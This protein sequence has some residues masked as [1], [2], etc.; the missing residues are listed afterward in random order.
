MY[1]DILWPTNIAPYLVYDVNAPSNFVNDP[2]G[3]G[4]LGLTIFFEVRPYGY[5]PVYDNSNVGTSGSDAMRGVAAT[6]INRSRSNN[7]DVSNSPGDPWLTLATKDMSPSIW[8]V[9]KAG[10]GGLQSSFYSKLIAILN[11][12][13]HTQDCDGLMHSWQ[14]AIAMGNEY[15]NFGMRAPVSLDTT[16]PFPGTLFFNTDDSVPSVSKAQVAFLRKLGFSAAPVYPSSAVD[17]WFWG[18][19]D[20]TQYGGYPAQLM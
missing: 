16:S 4:V 8:K 10:T 11:G 12:A 14:M 13:Q 20:A 2:V 6:A 3:E 19:T 7:V 9:N 18:L 5:E 17:W 1:T 15:A